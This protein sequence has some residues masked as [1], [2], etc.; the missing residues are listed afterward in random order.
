[1]SAT[2]GNPRLLEIPEEDRLLLQERAREVAK[3]PESG[4]LADGVE[5]LEVH[6]RGQNYALPLSAVSSITELTSIASIPRAPPAIRG[7]VS[8]RGE[9]LLGVELALLTGGGGS[10]IA[11]LR[12]VVVVGGENVRVAILAERI[13][14]VRQVQTSNFRAD[15]LSQYPFVM[16]TDENFLSLVDP[17]AL[18]N[19]SFRLVG[20]GT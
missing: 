19:F 18:I 17:G 8:V 20:G 4:E 3:R 10:G 2:V 5:V 12:R 6:S 7:L 11:D 13:I 16:G 1:M 9:V 14:S 15:R